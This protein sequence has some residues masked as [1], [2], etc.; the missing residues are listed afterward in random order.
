MF[1][2]VLDA[3]SDAALTPERVGINAASWRGRSCAQLQENYAQTRDSQQRFAANGDSTMVKTMGWQLDVINQ[4][5]G[6]QGC[7]DGATSMAAVSQNLAAPATPQ[8]ANSAP[9]SSVSAAPAQPAQP[10][11]A[12]I[13]RLGMTLQRP[14]AEML[15]AL[16]LSDADGAWVVSVEPDGPAARAGLKPLDVILEVSGQQVQGPDDVQAIAGRLRGGYH[17]PLGIW[18]ERAAKELTLEIPARVATTSVATAP[19]AVAAAAPGNTFCHAYVHVVDRP[20]GLQSE[21]FQTSTSE[22]S[23]A[24]MISSLS[25]FVS[26]VRQLHPD[27]WRPFTFAQDQCTPAAGYCF[28]QGENPLFG[29]KQMAGQFCFASREQAQ[30]HYDQFNAV[31]PVYQTVQLKP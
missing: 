15:K 23:A 11:S 25:A 10:A 22:L 6:E 28:G 5:R 31:K 4:V 19:V 8:V 17:A 14:N 12:P 20:G 27:D 16:G 13:Q 24:A 2:P 7:Q 21:L 30:Q 26:K 9:G 29:G 1:S 18:R 3:A